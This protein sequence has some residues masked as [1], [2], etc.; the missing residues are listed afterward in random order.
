[1][2]IYDMIN[3]I[4]GSGE[5]YEF[6]EGK[7]G[8]NREIRN[9]LIIK[10]Y[11]SG[12]KGYFGLNGTRGYGVGNVEI[13]EDIE[14]GCIELAKEVGERLIDKLNE[15]GLDEREV[16]VAREDNKKFFMQGMKINEENN[17]YISEGL[18]NALNFKEGDEIKVYLKHWF[19]F[20]LW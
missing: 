7:Y 13:S 10:T 16:V 5:D 3:K 2:D 18:A 8:I 12:N 1:M 4:E 17:T 19:F 14:N 11:P 9:G 20:K 6:I 15:M